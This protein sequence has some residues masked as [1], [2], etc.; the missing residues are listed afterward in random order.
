MRTIE[1]AKCDLGHEHVTK[2]EN[3]CDYRDGAARGG[4]RCLRIYRD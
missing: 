2:E 4:W 1:T 3:Y